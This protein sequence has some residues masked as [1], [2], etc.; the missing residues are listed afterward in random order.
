MSTAPE[1]TTPIVTKTSSSGVVRPKVASPKALKV[2]NLSPVETVWGTKDR[3]VL[4]RL[5]SESEAYHKGYDGDQNYV[6]IDPALNSALGPGS[7]DVH[8][9]IDNPSSII[10]E[11]GSITWVHGQAEVERLEIDLS[12]LE[13]GL[14][15][16]DG[17]FQI[18]YTLK[19]DY[20]TSDSVVPGY[21]IARVKDAELY[22]AAIYVGSSRATSY[23]DDYFAISNIESN[24]S[25]WPGR[26]TSAGSYDQG[27]WYTIDFRAPVV[28]EKFELLD[29]P[30]E[31]STATAAVYF[32]DDA[33][34]WYKSNEVKLL[35]ESWSLDV[36]GA[37]AHRYWKFFFWDGTASLSQIKYTGEAY[38]PD[39][40]TVGPITI[41][42]PYIDDLYEDITGTHITLAH[43]TI[44]GG[45]IAEVRDQ[46]QVTYTKYEPV[47]EWLTTF[48]D[49]Q[50]NFLFEDVELYSQ[51]YL[52]PLTAD[53]HTYYEMD[54]TVRFGLG[55]LTIGSIFDENGINFPEEVEIKER[56]GLRIINPT[57][58]VDFSSP[59]NTDPLATSQTLESEG[60]LIGDDIV[61]IKADGINL[62]S[63]A[64]I[65]SDLVTKGD[66]DE[67]FSQP[68]NLDD[69]F[70]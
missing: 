17:E 16:Q 50:L 68:W 12:Q 63:S 26:T 22:D 41:A 45:N 2:L 4:K 23:H 30:N 55:E 9:S 46:R 42:E 3:T 60:T 35:D 14:G 36:R 21:S 1:L 52:A 51:K 6:Y 13:N 65:E 37:G 56:G 28:A 61:G 39:L 33:I 54:D 69:G 20:P 59:L 40:R 49:E 5:P 10:V 32:S 38:F 47:S 29:D 31:T 27:S 48:Q 7:L 25:W 44:I 19:F 67:I 18:G 8:Y 62:V 66:T 53:Y 64:L 34:V 43:F 58:E 11:S 24:E 57:L 15:L 70:Y